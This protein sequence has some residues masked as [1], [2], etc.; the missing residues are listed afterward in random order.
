MWNL[1]WKTCDLMFTPR[2]RITQRRRSRNA[3]PR[4]VWGFAWRLLGIRRSIPRVSFWNPCAG[5]LM[6]EPRFVVV[7][8]GSLGDIVHT[9]PAV[10]TL[11]ESFPAAEIAWVTQP[12]WALLIESSGL[13]SEI[14]PV[15]SRDL[16]SVRKTVRR[17]RSAHWDAAIDYQGLWKSATLPFFGG[18]KR[19]IGFS[20]HTIREF[21]VP[22]LYTERVHVVRTHI[23]EQNGELSMRAGAK[24]IVTAFNLRVAEQ[25]DAVVRRQL[26][27]AGIKNYIVLSPGGGWRSKCW[28][29]ERFG[30]LC[31]KIRDSLGLR[32]VVNFGP[33]EDDL[34]DAVRAA[35]GN[36]EPLLY[37]AGLGEL[38]ALLQSAQCVV[39]GDTGPLHLAIALGTPAVALYGPT[40]PARHRP[41]RIDHSGGAGSDIVLRVAGAPTRPQPVRGPAPSL[42]AIAVGTALDALPRRPGVAA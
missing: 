36:A 15:E 28:L 22:A 41:F 18:V 30:V 32:S 17:L 4:Y 29:A 25:D 40:D 7:R 37:N 21:G 8:L 1:C 42:L 10:A 5:R 39:G 3:P 9:F 19:R 12:R 11:R 27:G 13:A 31:R 26:P 20:S 38:M 24:N 35:S 33:G 34:A 2:A 14:C 6:R 16:A 23:A